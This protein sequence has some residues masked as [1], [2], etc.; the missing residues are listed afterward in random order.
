MRLIPSGNTA[1]GVADMPDDAVS[2]DACWSHI[3]KRQNVLGLSKY[4][5][6]GIMVKAFWLYHT[7]AQ[8]LREAFITKTV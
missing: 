5:S 3:L 8:M 4:P 1:L 2:V 6:L 7:G